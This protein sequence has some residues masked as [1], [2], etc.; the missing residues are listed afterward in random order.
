[1]YQ[2]SIGALYQFTS[3]SDTPRFQVNLSCRSDG[4][5]DAYTSG[6]GK[7]VWQ[8]AFHEGDGVEA[9]STFQ[10]EGFKELSCFDLYRPKAR[11]RNRCLQNLNR[12]TL[13]WVY[14]RYQRTPV[15]YCNSNPYMLSPVQK[16]ARDESRSYRYSLS[17]SPAT[18][19]YPDTTRRRT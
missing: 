18:R 10:T 16:G 13:S 19:H 17:L 8:A 11:I 6:G 4:N 5:T 14:S 2:F 7:C 1:M 12:I 15:S 3:G 9:V